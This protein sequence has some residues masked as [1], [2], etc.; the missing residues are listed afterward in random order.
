MVHKDKEDK[1]VEEEL[2]V[3]EKLR[4]RLSKALGKVNDRL[5]DTSVSQALD[6]ATTDLKEMGS[7]PGR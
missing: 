2:A 5:T 7:T 1:A 6:K 4:Q 3:Y